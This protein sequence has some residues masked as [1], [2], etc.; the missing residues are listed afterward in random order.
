MRL[1]WAFLTLYLLAATDLADLYRGLAVEIVLL[2]GAWV[3]L[4][5]S[6]LLAPGLARPWLDRVEELGM[7]ELL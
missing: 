3:G 2:V 1:T 7:G 6:L 4:V 5:P